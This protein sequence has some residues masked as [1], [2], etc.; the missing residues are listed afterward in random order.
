M[1]S[2]LVS[3]FPKAVVAKT[4]QYIADTIGRSSSS[5][6]RDIY[7]SDRKGCYPF[8]TSSFGLDLSFIFGLTDSKSIEESEDEDLDPNIQ[9]RLESWIPVINQWPPHDVPASRTDIDQYAYNC[10]NFN[11]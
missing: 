5:E 1:W 8:F 9:A 11:L 4:S 3:M 2:S 7:S 6:S 10:A